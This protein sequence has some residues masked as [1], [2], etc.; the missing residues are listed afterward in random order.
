[1][2]SDLGHAHRDDSLGDSN[3][4]SVTRTST[5]ARASISLSGLPSTSLPSLTR[6][7]TLNP[8]RA[9][10]SRPSAPA[11]ES[12][13]APVDGTMSSHSARRQSRSDREYVRVVS[14][15]AARA[16]QCAPHLLP[17]R[18]FSRSVHSNTLEL[19]A[20]RSFLSFTV[21]VTSLVTVALPAVALTVKL[22]VLSSGFSKS[23]RRS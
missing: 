18:A 16:P 12:V 1:M 9:S 13:S 14:S 7:C 5:V 10:K 2:L 21:T 20:G 17:A 6:T 11:A 8:D 19:N 23:K 22:S 15:S 4:T 3:S